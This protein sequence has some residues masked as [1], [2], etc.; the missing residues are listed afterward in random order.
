MSTAYHP[1]EAEVTKNDDKDERKYELP[2]L[3]LPSKLATFI[4]TFWSYFI[5][6]SAN[7][8]FSLVQPII[9][10]EEWFR[11]DVYDQS[12]TGMC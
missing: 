1:G 6:K 12:A 5:M 9:I 4:L 3:P 8:C 2:V 10:Q 7:K 11:S